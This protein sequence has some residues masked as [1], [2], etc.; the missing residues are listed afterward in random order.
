MDTI[1]TAIQEKRRSAFQYI[2]CAAEKEKVLKHNG[3]RYEFS[4]YAQIWSRDYDY[5]VGWSE[6][7]GKLAAIEPLAVIR[8]IP[9]PFFRY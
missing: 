9:P 8:R 1:H 6:K 4:P 3:Y 7:Y 5:A 2:E